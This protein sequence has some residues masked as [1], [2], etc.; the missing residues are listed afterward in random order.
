MMQLLS[1]NRSLPQ[2]IHLKGQ[3]FTTG[4]YKTPAAGRIRLHT[5]GLEGDGQADLRVHGGVDKAVYLYPHE[6][7]AYWQ[8]TLGRTDLTP[9][10]FGENFTVSGLLETEVHQGDV[11]CVGSAVIQITEPRYPCFKLAIKME[12]RDFPKLF[13]R[14]EFSGFYARVREEGEAGAGDPIER[15]THFPENPTIQALVHETRKKR[16]L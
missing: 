12:R 1:L 3:T 8:Q 14:S 6:H 9:G 10:Q 16:I 4:I 13:L 11:F 15:L 2:T 7:Y 5:L